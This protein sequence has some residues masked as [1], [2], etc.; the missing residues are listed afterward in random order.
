MQQIKANK[1]KLAFLMEKYNIQINEKHYLNYEKKL[2]GYILFTKEQYKR[3]TRDKVKLNSKIV[4]KKWKKLCAEEKECYTLLAKKL[5]GREITRRKKQP[6]E[7]KKLKTRGD[8][9]DYFKHK[10]VKI[11]TMLRYVTHKNTRYLVDCFDNIIDS[12]GNDI[13]H[14]NGYGK[15]VIYAAKKATVSA[16]NAEE[17]Q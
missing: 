5:Y 16:P 14:I 3:Q 17:A 1:K 13:G 4:S 7:F 15:F 9:K 8:E 11:T 10:D 6:E 2:T 12:A